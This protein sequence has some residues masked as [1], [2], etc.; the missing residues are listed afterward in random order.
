MLLRRKSPITGF[1][2]I[3]TVPTVFGCVLY[4]WRITSILNITTALCVWSKTLIICLIIYPTFKDL[5]TP[6]AHL[7][8]GCLKISSVR[9]NFNLLRAEKHFEIDNPTG[10]NRQDSFSLANTFQSTFNLKT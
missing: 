3:L 9:L 1:M 8:S 7:S 2:H 10:N 6:V 4:L 5:Q